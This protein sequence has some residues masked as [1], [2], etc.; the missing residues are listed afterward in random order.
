MTPF[1]TTYKEIGNLIN[2]GA[3][4]IGEKLPSER[5]LA[6]RFGVSRTTI[7]TVIEKLVTE[8]R[9]APFGKRGMKVAERVSLAPAMN[10]TG[11]LT[12][13]GN[14][15][16]LIGIPG[17]TGYPVFI[18][19][20][21]LQQANRA[22]LRSLMLKTEDLKDPAQI[23]FLKKYLNGLLLTLPPEQ[24]NPIRK[25]LV[26]LQKDGIPIVIH[27]DSFEYSEFDTVTSDHKTGMQQI[28]RHM[29]ETNKKTLLYINFTA[30]NQSGQ[31]WRRKREEGVT[32]TAASGNAKAKIINVPLLTE[33]ANEKKAFNEQTRLLAGT[34]LELISE[35]FI[36]DAILTDSDQHIF[37]VAAALKLMGKIPGK[38]I[39]VTGYDNFWPI[40]KEREWIDFTPTA[41]ISKQ[42]NL[43]GK[44][45]VDLLLER[46]NTQPSGKPTRTIITPE[47]IIN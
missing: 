17:A 16:H 9:I 1:E 29:L 2:S 30:K 6:D 23:D 31:K 39:P 33:F 22:E 47:I 37:P 26:Q 7:H 24:M 25:E 35:G 32:E 21:L 14:L 20:H 46:R 5:K 10:P 4:R 44:A 27:D 28:T 8:K 3:F 19:Y 43:L 11:I 36:F 34:F 13:V 41:T 40:C 18:E 45:M 12:E 42:N 38:D 15:D